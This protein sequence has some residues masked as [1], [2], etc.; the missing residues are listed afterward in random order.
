MQKFQSYFTGVCISHALIAD[1]MLKISNVGSDD[2]L[3]TFS[4]LYW[5]SALCILMVSTLQGA[6]RVVTT[7]T[8][9]S[10]RLLSIIENYKVRYLICI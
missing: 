10:E 7:D 9:T 8:F 2:I 5:L 6:V 4:S 1:Q 3:F